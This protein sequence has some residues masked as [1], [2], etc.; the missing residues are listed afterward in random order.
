MAANGHRVLL[1]RDIGNVTMDLHGVENIV[2]N[3]G[4]GDDAI[5][6]AVFRALTSL[7]IDGGDGNDTIIGSRG[8]DMLIGGDGDDIV[9]GAAAA[10]WPCLVAATTLHLESRRRQRRGRGPVRLR[11][12]GVQRLQVGEHID[13]SANGERARLF[14]DVGASPWTS[15]ASR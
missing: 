13:I 9:T 12:A 7:T 8:N 6:A 2:I 14:R 10:T 5:I 1:A 11:Y 3:A 15:T 4:G